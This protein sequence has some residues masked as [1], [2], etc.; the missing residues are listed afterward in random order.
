MKIAQFTFSLF[1]INTYVVWNPESLQCAVVDPGMISH[2]EEQALMGFIERNNLKVTHLI[3]THLHI[4]HVAG[5]R[6]IIDRTGALPEANIQD[7]PLGKRIAEQAKAFQLPFTPDGVDINVAL[8]DGDEIMIGS[9]KLNVIHV[10]GHSPGSIALYDER[11]GW[12]ISGDA[13]F[14]DSI[15]RTDLPGGS[16]ATLKTAIREKLFT[17]PDATVV[18]PGHGEPTTIGYEKKHNYFVGGF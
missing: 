6:F 5:N 8:Q 7:M 16:L 12:L 4:D 9:E 11:D 10:P 3:N 17:L 1:G 2:E 18:Y 13:L 15:G 14:R